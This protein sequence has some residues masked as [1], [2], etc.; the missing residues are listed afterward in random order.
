MAKKLISGH[1]NKKH[2]M[3]YII[4]YLTDPVTGKKKPNWFS[5]GLK[6]KGNLTKAN[7]M[8]LKARKDAT[9]GIL[10]PKQIPQDTPSESEQQVDVPLAPDM[11]FSDYIQMWLSA[12]RPKWEETTYVGY[13]LAVNNRIAPYFAQKKIKLSELTTMDIQNFYTF[14][15]QKSNLNGNTILHFHANIRK[16]LGDAIRIY[17]LI[18]VNPAADI[19]RPKIDN[20]VSG[21]YNA[22]QLSRMFEVFDGSSIEIPVILAAY[23]G[24]RRSEVIG[25]LWSSIDFKNHTITISHTVA[26]VKDGDKLRI[27]AKNRTKNKASFRTLPLIPQVEEILKQ[28]QLRQK[29]NRALCGKEYNLD[30]LDYICVND[31]GRLIYP[32]RVTSGFRERLMKSELPRIRYHDLRHS[33]AS[34]LLANG[35]SLK[36]IQLWLGHSNFSTTANIYA[37]LDLSSKKVTADTISQCLPTIKGQSQCERKSS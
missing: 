15:K 8:L 31:V 12:M 5:T 21:Y 37:H 13:N 17:K 27:V 24:L 4:L 33:C 22:E 29:R 16:S 36:E 6:V 18:S 26:R 25:L 11:L 10:P 19:D 28:E 30:Y 3:F 34:L 14:L 35:V 20:F 9:N 7:K 32:D 23:Y 2:D 1:L